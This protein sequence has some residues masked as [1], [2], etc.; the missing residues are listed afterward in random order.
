[1][2]LELKVKIIFTFIVII[3]SAFIVIAQ[4]IHKLDPYNPKY[5]SKTIIVKFKDN[6]QISRILGKGTDHQAAPTGIKSID[7][8]N[9]VYKIYSYQKVFKEPVA[10]SKN[11]Y[12]TDHMGVVNEVVNLDNIYKIRYDSEIDPKQLVELYKT[13]ENIDY[14][15]PDYIA[16]TMLTPNDSLF[17]NGSQWYLNTVNA[18]AAWDLTVGD[19][20][21]IIG[22]LD[23]GVD[24]LHPDLFNKIWTNPNEIPGNGI[25]DDLGGFV[26]D[27]HGW[28]FIN[29]DND[30]MDD[31]SH[32]THVAGIAA[33][34]SNNGSGISGIAWNSKI[35][36]VKVMQSSGE[37]NMSD[38][39]AGV[40]YAANHGATVINM[41]LG[42]YGESLTLKNALA[43]AYSTSTL[44]AAAGNDRFEVDPAPLFPACYSFVIGVMASDKAND[45]ALFSNTDL[46]GPIVANNEFGYNYEVMAPGFDIWSTVP[47]N[48]YRSL[49]GTSMAAPIVSGT[50]ALMRT[51]SPL[52]SNEDIF[53]KIIQSSDNGI[54]NIKNALNIKL[55]PMLFLVNTTIVDTLPG[56]DRDGIADVGETIELY[57]NI[58]NAGGTADS[59]WTKL[60]FGEFED[61]S[62]AAILNNISYLGK[63]STYS[64]LS[65]NLHPWKLSINSNLVD[66]RI[67]VFNCDIYSGSNK[68]LSIPIKI[69]VQRI[70]EVSGM[71]TQNQVWTPDK[72]Y[73]ITDNTRVIEGV[74][75]QVKPGTTIQLYPGKSLDI[76]GMLKM[77]GKPDSIII[78]TSNDVG[79]PGGGLVLSSHILE[80][81]IIIS[82]INYNHLK[83]LITTTLDYSIGYVN[84]NNSVFSYNNDP[85][86]IKFFFGNNICFRSCNF[87]YN[88]S[89]ISF[90]PTNPEFSD[91]LFFHNIGGS[92]FF[93]YYLF[94]YSNEYRNLNFNTII[95]NQ[96]NFISFWGSSSSISK[97]PNN[98]WGTTN[99]K[100][101]KKNFYDFYVDPTLPMAVFTPMLT[102]PSKNAHGHVWKVLVNNK[103]PQEET[104]DP[105]GTERVKFDVF[106][107]RAM[108]IKQTPFLTFGVREPFTQHTVKDSACWSAD[109]TVWTAYY[110]VDLTTGDGINIIRVA[111]ALDNEHFQIPEEYT[112]FKFV[113]QSA[114]SLSN[115]FNAYSNPGKIKLVWSSVNKID[116]LGY[117]M[118]RYENITDTT[119]T[120]KIKINNSLIT[121]TI[122]NDI[123][124]VAGKKYHY[125]YSVVSTALLES[126]LSKEVVAT[127]IL[128]VGHP[129]LVPELYSLSQNYPNPFN[130]S[131]II[132]YAVP[133]ESN[134]KIRFYNSLGQCVR[135][136]NE[137]TKRPGYYELKF[138]STGLASGIYF[139]SIKAVSTDGKN[140]FNAVKKMIIIK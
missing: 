92:Y 40:I 107:N 13:D 62:T 135:N 83:N 116:I 55:S 93:H 17:Q 19:T 101:I 97:L 132:N 29:N 126:D 103:N 79:N 45:L 90:E 54:L 110:N 121:D 46:S 106:F 127:A 96:E 41:S 87:L 11:K 28:D 125:M 33:A 99:E 21:Q 9:Y 74:T 22:I 100:D 124:I 49:S 36:P 82:Y 131:T 65:G 119:F 58:K 3:L 91:N 138:N 37:G 6:T 42:S 88:K 69:K 50:V 44:V 10:Y 35:M 48:G 59:I 4:P 84:I 27:I 113:I 70:F 72:I 108:D 30:P 75:L 60:S 18:P 61:T 63:L 76:K 137:S 139:Y 51:Y 43:N 15:E 12:F 81:T 111:Q 112:R 130:P 57:T 115:D 122:Y 85:V 26:D 39:A 104:I 25:D 71:I 128:S 38:V 98:Y 67:I 118:Y 66:N 80:D 53:A 1:M 5:A 134:I 129:D 109:S 16:Y 8:L 68:L 89:S 140:N 105:L 23:T 120:N 14:A 32:G 86:N 24:W 34:Q 114:G 20:T 77:I 52:I 47:H 64:Q 7:A 31:N 123:N 95:D 102:R 73:V 133:F 56:D 2:S 94:S 136:F 78:F 117:N